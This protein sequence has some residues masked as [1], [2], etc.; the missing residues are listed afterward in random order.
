VATQQLV[1]TVDGRARAVACE[2]MIANNAIR[3]LIRDGK[4]HQIHNAM[5]S[6]KRLGMQT[7]DDSLADLVR[8]GAVDMKEALRRAK[9]PDELTRMLG[10]TPPAPA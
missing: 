5:S 1:P 7:M 3:A 4:I 9:N 2:I 6:G 8:R 10:R